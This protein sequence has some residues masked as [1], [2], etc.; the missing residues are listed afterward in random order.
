ML[1]I[2]PFQERSKNTSVRQSSNRAN[3]V[4]GISM[5]NAYTQHGHSRAH[6]P[7]ALIRRTH[8]LAGCTHS[9]DALTCLSQSV[10]LFVWGRKWLKHDRTPDMFQVLIG[11]RFTH[12]YNIPSHWLK[13][14]SISDSLANEMATLSPDWLLHTSCFQ[15]RY[16]LS[17]QV[18]CWMTSFFAIFCAQLL[19]GQ[20]FCKIRSYWLILYI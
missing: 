12:L 10:Q 2:N 13:N 14:C 8:W 5:H 19:I 6:L 7:D 18:F 9:P 15:F 16:S 20:R 3:L 17:S 4:I 11:C 1:E